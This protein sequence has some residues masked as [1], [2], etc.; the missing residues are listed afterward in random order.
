MDDDHVIDL[1][2]QLRSGHPACRDC[3]TEFRRLHT[4]S[5]VLACTYASEG[6]RDALE[7]FESVV[8]GPHPDVATSIAKKDCTGLG[9][10]R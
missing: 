2:T 3:S 9:I 1:K 10:L 6:D 4:S 7:G 5:L 8:R